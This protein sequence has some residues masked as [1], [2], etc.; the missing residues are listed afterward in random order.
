MA[1][2]RLVVGCL[3]SV[4]LTIGCGKGE[5]PASQPS[6]QGDPNSGQ[7]LGRPCILLVTIDTWR[8]DYIGAS[9]SGKVATPFLDSL[10][11]DGTY[12]QKVQTPCPLTTPAHATILTGLTPARHGI[13]DNMHFR[14][15]TGFLTLP[16]ALQRAGYSTGAV[17]SGAPLRKL[18]G[19]DRGF[20]QYDDSGLGAEGDD[21]VAP[22]S[23][24]A[25]ATTAKA[26]Q[27]AVGASQRA[28][29]FLWVHYYDAHFPYLPPEAFR[30]Q[31]PKDL[32]AG[33]VAAL[34]M[35]VEELVKGIRA[36]HPGTWMICVT[37]DHGEALGEHGEATHGIG[38]YEPTVEVPLLLHPKSALINPEGH[39]SLLD[40]APTLLALAKAPGLGCEGSDLASAIPEGR[41]LT[42]ESAFPTLAFGLNPNLAVRRGSWIWLHHGADEVYDLASDP[43]QQRELSQDE[44]GKAFMREARGQMGTAFG[45]DPAAGMR[46]VSLTMSAKELEALRGLGY[47]DGSRMQ[48][49]LQTADLR[50]FLVDFQRFNDARQLVRTGDRKKEAIAVYETFLKRYRGSPLAW[51]EYGTSLLGVGDYAGAKRAFEQALSL[52]PKDA[53][54]SLNLGNL[55]AM[56][57]DAARAERLYLQSLAAEESQAEGHL[58]LGLL[59][60]Q[61]LKKPEKAAPHLQRFLELAPRDSEAARVQALLDQQRDRRLP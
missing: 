25:P 2:R 47:L 43:S 40:I 55:A 16:E 42:A 5:P 51:R 33:E 8:W 11:K 53:V 28:P 31:Y 39:P 32:Y 46:S 35:A 10:A 48:G 22:S 36:V 30:S 14:L 54:A 49:P 52:D 7:S 38:L 21:S 3:V 56:G 50:Q 4:L 19:L 24:P 9:G 17:V 13:R 23:R 12:F 18:Y 37:G 59:Y 57:G 58:N 15:E 20:Q 1:C 60:V 29:L 44:R 6:R 45:R 41:W 34:D 26:I 61:M 27:L